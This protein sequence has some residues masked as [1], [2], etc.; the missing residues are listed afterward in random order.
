[1][2]FDEWGKSLGGG[3]QKGIQNILPDRM[4]KELVNISVLDWKARKSMSKTIGKTIYTL[5]HSERLKLFSFYLGEE[6]LLLLSA[7][8]DSDTGII[9]QKVIEIYHKIKE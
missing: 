6:T 8:P 5:A 9:V 1:M 3:M 4:R 2:V 7:E